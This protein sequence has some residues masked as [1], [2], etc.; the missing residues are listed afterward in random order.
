METTQLKLG[1]AVRAVLAEANEPLSSVQIRELVKSKYPH[2]YRTEPHRIGIEK[3]HYQS[4]DH[5]L[6]NPIYRLVTNSSDFI[7]DRSQKPMLVSLASNEIADE[8]PEEDYEAEFGTVYVLA[9]GLFTEKQQRIIK[10][11]YT[12]QTL[13]A[14]IAQLFTTGTPF[15]FKK[16]HSW[17]VKNYTQLEQAIHLLLSPFRLNR[18]REFFTEEVLPHVEAIVKIHNEVQARVQ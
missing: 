11:G 1:E 17:H 10:I 12:T 13:E 14:R 16:L 18:A 7:V 5:A 4:F 15:Q 9:T 2:L 3:G 6:L 8:S